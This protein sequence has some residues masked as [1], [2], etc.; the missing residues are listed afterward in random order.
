LESNPLNNLGGLEDLLAGTTEEGFLSRALLRFDVSSSIPAGASITQ[1][2]LFVAVVL[3][4]LGGGPDSNFALHRLLRDWGEG[5]KREFSVGSPASAGEATWLARFHPATLW[6]VP[7]GEARTDYAEA[8][9]SVVLVSG[10]DVYEFK[11]SAALIADVQSWLDDP[12]SNA[13]WMLKTED[14]LDDSTSRCFASREDPFGDEP[15]L[16][17]KYT[18]RPRIR[19]V[20]VSGNEFCLHF[21]GKAGKAYIVEGRNAVQSGAWTVVTNIPPL[22]AAGNLSVCEPLSSGNRFYRVGEQ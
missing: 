22:A 16:V 2:N 14:E 17:V 20:E 5:D 8:P 10:L 7:G 19:H 9:S 12:G 15:Q 21:R 6:T 11:S 13:G 18:T 1:V 4:P 3:P